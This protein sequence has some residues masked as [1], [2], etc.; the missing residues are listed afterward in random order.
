MEIYLKSDIGLVR[1]TNQDACKCG[2]FE[3]DVLWAV[4]CD[5]MGG[6]NAG[7]IASSL[8][9]ETIASK[10]KE[11]YSKDLNEE[12]IYT[13]L[14]KSVKYT[15]NLLYEKQ[16]EKPEYEG[17]GTTLELVL[18]NSN[19][20]CAVHVGDSRVYLIRDKKIKQLTV[21][22][23]LVQEMVDSGQIT[24]EEAQTHPKRHLITR[25]LG[26]YPQVRLDYIET[27]LEKND[28]IIMCTDGLTNYLSPQQLVE[29][30]AE[31]NGR[32]L[33]KKLVEKAKELG[34]S[35]NITVSVIFN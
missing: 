1:K 28:I 15:N 7:N 11:K 5:G 35:D 31:R 29:Y 14:I 34:G 17:M 4:V 19:K 24:Q 16:L 2:S 6:A 22:H 8:A 27:S 10:L 26:V 21:D 23:S 13:L 33:V 9:V 3:D 12:E 30:V 25:A 32:V 20:I 18:I